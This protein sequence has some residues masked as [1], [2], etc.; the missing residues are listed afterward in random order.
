MGSV[1]FNKE[2]NVVDRKGSGTKKLFL[3]THIHSYPH[4]HPPILTRTHTHIPILTHT[5]LYSHTQTYT[6]TYVPLL[7]HTNLYTHTQTYLYLYIRTYT[8][9]WGPS[10]EPSL[11]RHRK[12]GSQEI[13]GF[14]GDF[15]VVYECRRSVLKCQKEV[16]VKRTVR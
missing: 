4:T 10:G 1:K 13:P 2:H 3:H 7:I 8:H 12:E 11:G 15:R 16:L 9:R 5:Y 14:P 6:H